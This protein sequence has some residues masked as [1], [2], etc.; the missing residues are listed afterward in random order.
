MPR[1]PPRSVNYA[2]GTATRA[3]KICCGRST[4][5]ST[6]S[7][8]TSP[9]TRDERSGKIR[10]LRHEVP[11]LPCAELLRAPALDAAAVLRS[12]GL[13]RD[14]FSAGGAGGGRTGVASGRHTAEQG[15]ERHLH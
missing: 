12:L 4:I 3:P 1:G 10:P 11:A 5:R 2:P 9:E 14:R 6:L 8:T 13:R 15:A 7:S